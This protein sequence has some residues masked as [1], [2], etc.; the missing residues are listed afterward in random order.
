M[1][2]EQSDLMAQLQGT[3]KQNN[4]DQSFE[5]NGT[6][7]LVTANGKTVKTSF[8]LI[9]NLQLRNWQIKVTKPMAWLRT[10]I[11]QITEDAF[12]IYDFDLKVNMA[13]G[14]RSKLL[15]PTRTYKYTR[16]GVPAEIEVV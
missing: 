6:E 7:L 8:E 12:V 11:V 13:M 16:V 5:I 3:W 4:D 10:F 9:R 15:N 2:I 14:A 1:D